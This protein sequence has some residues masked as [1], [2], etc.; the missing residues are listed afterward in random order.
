VEE[1]RGYPALSGVGLPAERPLA[2]DGGALAPIPGGWLLRR[3]QGL[4]PWRLLPPGARGTAVSA[5]AFSLTGL[6]FSVMTA[7]HFP[8][9]F[10]WMFLSSLVPLFW[11]PA[12]A[13]RRL[14]R[15]A[16][17][18]PYLHS[19]AQRR[20]GEVV[21]IRGR[22]RSGAS[23]ESLGLRRQVV[24]A[25]YA[26]TVT[27]V[28]GHITDGLERP[29]HETRGIDFVVDLENGETVTV[30]TRGAYLSPQPPEAR[31]IFW[32]RN[33]HALPT[34]LRRVARAEAHGVVNETIFGETHLA[35]GD[36]VE[37]LGVLDYEIR[38]EAPAATRGARLSPVLRADE[39]TPLLLRR[40][41]DDGIEH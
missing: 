16:A 27:Y 39:L 10:L 20:R 23:F 31:W 5:S 6:A 15:L 40:R 4:R 22:I 29:W 2:V 36:Q 28:S 13:E 33:R 18:S 30:R 12:L 14:R 9:M 25:S 32:G 8:Q 24:L 38:P 1:S 35:P 21:K 26:G 37:V 41:T 19:I 7:N 34:P 17:Q 11:A 3:V